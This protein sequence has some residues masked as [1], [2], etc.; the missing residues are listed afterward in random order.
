M[1]I[2]RKSGP[3]KS[4]NLLVFFRLTTTLAVKMKTISKPYK[5]LYQIKAHDVSFHVV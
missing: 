1:T 5:P 3:S 2:Y 4:D